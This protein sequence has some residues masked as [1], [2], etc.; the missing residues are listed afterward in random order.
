MSLQKKYAPSNTRLL[1]E[2]EASLQLGIS[3]NTLQ[4]WRCH[5]SD[6]LPYYKF[7]RKVRYRTEDVEEFESRRLNDND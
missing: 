3:L 1:T 2:K 5:K 7:S 4:Y 6:K